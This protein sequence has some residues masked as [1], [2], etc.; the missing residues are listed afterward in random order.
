MKNKLYMSAIL[1]LLILTAD[2]SY[3]LD[4]NNMKYQFSLRCPGGIVEVGDREREVR[5]KCGNPLEIVNRPLSAPIWIYHFYNEK[6]MFYL[7]ISYGN[8]ERIGVAPL[9]PK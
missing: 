4:L 2:K 7:T 9:Q 5:K 3:C 1:I 6:Y 8:L